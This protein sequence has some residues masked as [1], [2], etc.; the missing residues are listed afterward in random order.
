MRAAVVCLGLITVGAGAQPQAAYMLPDIGAPG[1]AVAVEIVARHDAFG[2]FGSDGLYGNEPGDSVRV[3]CARPADTAFITLGPVVVSWGGR[4]ISTHVF[5]HPWVRPNSWRWSELRPEFRIPIQVTVSGRGVVV[6]TFYIVQPTPIGRYTGSE[7]TLGEG[8]LGVR[9]RRG[10]MVVDSLLLPPGEAF[11]VSVADCDPWTPSNQGYLPC[12]IMSVG[13]IR[14]GVGTTLSVSG[15]GKDAGPGGGGGGGAFCDVL[16]GSAQGSDGGSGFT[17]GGR[18]GKNG[19]GV[20]SNEYRSYGSSTGPDGASLNGVAPGTSPQYESAGGG[21]GHPFGTSGQGCRDGNTCSPEGGYGGGSGFRQRQA[22]GAGGYAT[23]GQSSG[24][25]NGGREHG[26]SCLVP[27]AGGSGGASGNPQGVNV[28]SGDGGGGGGALRVVAPVIEELGFLANGAPGS[29]PGTP[30]AGPGGGGS[31][32]A[33]HLCAPGGYRGA[34]LSVLGGRAE[35]TPTGGAGRVRVDGPELRPISVQPAEAT[36]FVGPS[37]ALLPP[38]PRQRAVIQGTGNGQAILLYGKPYGGQWRP[39]DT[40]VGYGT[41]WSTTVTLPAP[42]T[43]F[44]LVALQQIP[45]PSTASFAMEPSWVVSPAA[46][47]LV[48]V[49]KLPRLHAPSERTVDTVLCAGLERQDTFV[50]ANR[51]EAPLE[52]QW[53]QFV[54]GD[55]GFRLVAPSAGWFPLVV[56]PGDSVRFIVAFQALA[57]VGVFRDTL[58]LIHTDTLTAGSPWRIAYS[59]VK[60]TLS[61]VLTDGTAPV[62]MYDFGVLCPREERTALIMV[63]NTAQRSLRLRPPQL[64]GS[65]LWDVTPSTALIL[66]PGERQEL[67]VR[68]RA[69]FVGNVSGALVVQEADCGYADTVWLAASG[70]VTRLE[71]LG[72]GQFGPVRIGSS[73]ELTVVLQNRGYSAAWIP[74]APALSPP[75]ELVEMRPP[76][77]VRLLPQQ[78]L[79]FRVRYSPTA[80]QT[81]AAE[82]VLIAEHSDSTCPDTARLLLSGVGVRI[83]AQVYPKLLDFG[84][85]SRCENPVDTVW[86]KNTGTVP[87]RIVR[88]AAIVGPDATDFVVAIQPR[89]PLA[90]DPADSVLYVVQVLPSGAPGVRTAQLVIMVDDTVDPALTVGLRVERISPFVAIPAAVDLGT[91]R[92]GQSSQ[93]RLEGRN[94]L[95]RPLTVQAVWSSRPEVVV[96]PQTVVIPAAGQQSFVVTVTPQQLGVLQ[97]ELFFLVSDP[98]PDTHRVLV[99][100]VVT[101]EGVTYT[102]VLDFGAVAFCEERVDTLRISNETADTLWLLAAS[103]SGGDAG[104]FAVQLPLL[105]VYIA[106]GRAERY[107]VIFRPFGAPDGIRSAW[108]RLSARVGPDP[109]LMEVFLSGRRETPL[110]SAPPQVNFGVIFAGGSSQQPVVLSNRGNLPVRVDSVWLQQGSAFRLLSMPGLPYELAPRESVRF[111]VE[112][113]PL[114]AG[115]QVDTLRLRIGRPCVD[116][117]VLL[118]SGIGVEPVELHVWFPDTQASPWDRRVRIPLYFA[119]SPAGYQGGSHWAEM[120]LEYDPSLFLLRGVSRGQI[121]HQRSVGGWA[122]VAVRVESV[123]VASQGVITELFGDVLLGRVEETPLR[124][125]SFLWDDGL[126]S[127]QTRHTDGRLRLSGLCTE[128][129]PRL[130]RPVGATVLRAQAQGG[131]LIVF[132][133]AGERGRYRLE[134]YSLEGR[135]IWE[136]QWSEAE[137]GRHERLWHLGRQA[138]GVYVVVFRTPTQGQSVLVP[139]MSP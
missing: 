90:V 1:M 10:A 29:V 117:R 12:V 64:I 38:L 92:R 17:S 81:D 104:F 98:C 24:G 33:L 109:L 42:D 67:T 13:P 25:S 30:M 37:I 20:G 35:G 102:S 55:R 138:A 15:E 19:L 89:V 80:A 91:L 54:Y 56:A 111:V 49:A 137:A 63:V 34:V 3:H 28:C 65:A 48:T 40:L 126:L 99:R 100:A 47:R 121:V 51:G 8:A 84:M 97:A 85:V 96:A 95:P 2:T 116:E 105:P 136:V 93:V 87:I 23:Q 68:C 60:D 36:R 9:S 45:N 26:N 113:H 71:W 7:R 132:T 59:A 46:A 62:G 74:T 73:A 83:S 108:L 88:P 11:R 118:L 77:P 133:S 69:G 44:F 79:E 14:G 58:V 16:L 124:I 4:L 18:G 131:E 86:L 27:L 107:A 120:E 57:S 52:I 139:V 53:A 114:Q 31:G 76:A 72:S 101:G 119:L 130:L 106:P 21:T 22:G 125:V 41:R 82:L 135:R 94:L 103:L 129:G 50:V 115:R 39:W 61:F 5:V 134:L 70:A 112:F 43:L 32:G 128:G 6:D 122:R 110:L 78:Q 75:F 127:M 123:M 66:A